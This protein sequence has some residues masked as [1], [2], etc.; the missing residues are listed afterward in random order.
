M[1]ATMPFTA[2]AS[3]HPKKILGLDYPRLAQLARLQGKVEAVCHVAENGSVKS[4]GIR[5]GH[6]VLARAV[7]EN[8]LQWVFF[9]RPDPSDQQVIFE[10]ELLDV[11]DTS[12]CRQQFWF[13]YP[14]IVRVIAHQLPLNPSSPRR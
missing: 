12:R 4:V 8:L 9:S 11:C 10:F 13:E 3:G 2:C 5:S 7:E 6:P 14:N 1:Y